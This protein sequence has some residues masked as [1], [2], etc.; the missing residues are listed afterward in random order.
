MIGVKHMHSALH[1]ENLS[2][3][4]RL[5]RSHP[6]K[7]RTLRETIAAGARTC[8]S[9]CARRLGFSRAG[10]ADSL[11]ESD[12]FWALKDV[13]C[14]VQPG[15][16]VG[17]MGSNGAG[18][19]TLLKTVSKIMEPTKGRIQY[20][21][22][23]AS[24]LEV[25]TG[26]HPEL[27]GRENIFLNAAILG[28][29]GREIA[30]KF[31]EIVSFAQV[32]EF[33]D[34]PVKRYSSGMYVRL[35]FAVAANLAP[36]I[37]LVDE[38]LAVGDVEFQKKCL[39]RMQDGARAGQTVL[40]VSHNLTALQAICT[41]GI[42]LKAG[43]LIADG[44]ITDVIGSY[45]KTLE[46]MANVDLRERTDRKG[47]GRVRLERVEIT[48]P[49]LNT[50]GTVAIGDPVQLAFY[51]N[52]PARGVRLLFKI[53]DQNGYSLSKINSDFRGREDS[54]DSSCPSRYVCIFDEFLLA[55]GRYHLDVTLSSND[56][57][58][59]EIEGAAFFDVSRAPVRGRSVPQIIG[60]WRCY[61][62]NRWV[63]PS[64]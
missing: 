19:S 39:D 58:E 30:R 4:F 15:E 59:D 36:D 6:G 12:T 3:S 52:K 44:L 18:K 46:T 54:Y 62:P 29:T 24:L 17:V 55:P 61:M 35:G 5:N 63:F 37:L 50:A 47:R 23:V 1:I 16:I 60:D 31:D 22:R 9:G 43:S 26:F 21:G 13:S 57:I 14:Q 64:C 38:V 40:F 10:V 2:K 8:V 33:L 28:M 11:A 20:R 56:Q 34:V 49:D 48:T 53:V 51:M 41:R 42:L 32:E 25:G 27:T 45:L 7:Y